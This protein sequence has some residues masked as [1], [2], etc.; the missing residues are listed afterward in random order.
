VGDDCK[1][2]NGFAE[3]IYSGCNILKHGRKLRDGDGELGAGQG[4]AAGDAAALA[5]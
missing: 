3:H 2:G 5:Q 4:K 1:L